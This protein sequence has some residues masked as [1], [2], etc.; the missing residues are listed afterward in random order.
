MKSRILR[1]P[2]KV[3]CT[4]ILLGGYESA[5]RCGFAYVIL[6]EY[7][8]PLLLGTGQITVIS[9]ISPINPINPRILDSKTRTE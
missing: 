1:S 2:N 6:G 4:C 3:P 7:F 8:C 5:A 9:P